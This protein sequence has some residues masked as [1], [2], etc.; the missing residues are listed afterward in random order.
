MIPKYTRR[1]LVIGLPGLVLQLVGY[2]ALPSLASNDPGQSL[3][4][5]KGMALAS[6]VGLLSGTILF[7]AGVYY[8]AKAKGYHGA[9]GFIGLFSWVGLLIIALLPDKTTG[10]A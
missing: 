1:S 9:L 10:V 3:E 2:A 5:L 4:A 7:V 8:Y 6:E